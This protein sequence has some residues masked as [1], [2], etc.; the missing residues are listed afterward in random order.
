MARLRPRSLLDR[1][2]LVGVVLCALVSAATGP[3]WGR[4]DPGLYSVALFVEGS[5]VDP[6]GRALASVP[7]GELPWERWP[8]T[9]GIRADDEGREVF[10]TQLRWRLFHYSLG[11]NG[12]DEGTL[13]D[14]LVIGLVDGRPQRAVLLGSQHDWQGNPKPRLLLFLL[15]RG[16]TLL[17]LALLLL[18]YLATRPPRLPSLGDPRRL[19][20]ESAFV[21]PLLATP[22]LAY[23]FAVA[24]EFYIPT[25]HSSPSWDALLYGRVH[26]ALLV[27]DLRAQATLLVVLLWLAIFAVRLTHP[28]E[29]PA[30]ATS[31]E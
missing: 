11:P 25:D 17:L 13:G 24:Q 29:E 27:Q 18:L 22:L 6:W 9:L 28:A 8:L 30:C 20:L 14:D 26:Q 3:V 15:C 31:T 21:T 4:L 2:L 23:A 7:L 16:G 5:R 12:V 1:A 10:V 19:A